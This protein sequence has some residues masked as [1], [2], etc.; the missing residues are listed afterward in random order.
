[1]GR[2]Q[3]EVAT[4]LNVNE[5]TYL[6]WEGDRNEP[7]IRMWPKLIG[8]LGYDPNCEPK[9]DGEALMALRRQFGLSRKRMAKIAGCDEST[10]E[11]L[12]KA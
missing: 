4:L 8:F 1:M 10:V 6:L 3:K 7:T 12:E 5:W 11:R 9:T 2:T